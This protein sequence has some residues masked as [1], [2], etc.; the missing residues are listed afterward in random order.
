M[1]LPRLITYQ[2]YER[3]EGNC[4][5]RIGAILDRNMNTMDDVFYS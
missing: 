2:D 4:T 5:L 3:V 1:V